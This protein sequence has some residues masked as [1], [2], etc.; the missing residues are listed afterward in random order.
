MSADAVALWP[1]LNRLEA[2]A[3]RLE[4][5]AA[6][7]RAEVREALRAF[8]RPVA[9]YN[10]DGEEYVITAGDVLAI[11][12]RL[13]KPHSEETI[14]ELV[15]AHKMAERHRDVPPTERERRFW[16]NVKAIRAEA[17]AKGTAVDDPME[18]V[19]DD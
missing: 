1:L 12:E 16:T 10:V 8:D 19:G 11:R 2:R 13:V 17:I 7:L 4:D 6:A 14:R 18:A 5:E 9:T 15:L 3:G